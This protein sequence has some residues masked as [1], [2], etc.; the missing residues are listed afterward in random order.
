MKWERVYTVHDFYD[1]PR[2]GVADFNGTP[3]IYDREF[4]ESQGEYSDRYWLTEIAPDLLTLVM[5]HWEI[6]LRWQ[7]AFRKGEATLL[8]PHVLPADL[9]RDSELKQLIGD[10]LEEKSKHSVLKRASFRYSE[11]KGEVSWLDL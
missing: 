8:G 6:W 11:E 10:R 3:H 7:V 5:E 1:Q 4:D 2:L 9:Q